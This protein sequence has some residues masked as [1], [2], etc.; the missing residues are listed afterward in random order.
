MTRGIVEVSTDS[1]E[2]GRPSTSDGNNIY[3]YSFLKRATEDDDASLGNHISNKI[4]NRLNN[5]QLHYAQDIV[6]DLPLTRRKHNGRLYNTTQQ[7]E[8]ENTCITQTQV[9][10]GQ[11]WGVK[12][13]L[14]HAAT[15]ARGVKWNALIGGG[16]N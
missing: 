11:L 3:R 1:N 5:S 16:D 2:Q 15:G 9:V 8:Q 4:I 10:Y 13:N 14:L 7:H 6:T 12:T